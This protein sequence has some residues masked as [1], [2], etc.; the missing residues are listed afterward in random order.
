MV[1]V[2]QFGAIMSHSLIVAGLGYGD[3]GKGSITEYLARKHNARLV[4]RYNGGHQA[5]HNICLADG[6]HHTFAQYGSATL[7]GIPTHLS[8]FMVV[9]PLSLVRE[10]DVLVSKMKESLYAFRRPTI[11]RECLV[12][13]KYHRAANRIREYLRGKNRHGSCGVGI[14]ETK[15]YAEEFPDQAIR[16]GDLDNR[17]ALL[18]KL[19]DVQRHYYTEFFGGRHCDVTEL[20][21][22]ARPLFDKDVDDYM[23]EL[24]EARG[25]FDIVDRDWL[26]KELDKDGVIV[27]E[28]AQGILLDENHGFHPFCTWSNCTYQN[29]FD[30]IGNGRRTTETYGIIRPYAHRHGP[31][32]LVT[33]DSSLTVHEPH[34]S[35]GRWQGGF[36]V[37]HFDFVTAGYAID[38]VRPD[39]IVITHCDWL[40]KRP[41][42]KVCQEYRLNGKPLEVLPSSAN[43]M[44]KS[45]PEYGTD[46]PSA[47]FLDLMRVALLDDIKLTSHGPTFEDK[48]DTRY[49]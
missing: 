12:T 29:A 41:A 24:C 43:D 20:L 27:F 14:A 9:N 31:G 25:C 21:A 37:G 42:V 38:L 1:P 2:S 34:N 4:V 10:H 36:R 28:G 15:K 13:T 30:L 46:V 40:V 39:H 19:M 45:D 11:E 48:V 18:A 44:M 6:T 33:E 16:I 8:R 32:P 26:Q 17:P 7:A 3:E 49:G 23:F 22:L 35:E 5:A 47:E